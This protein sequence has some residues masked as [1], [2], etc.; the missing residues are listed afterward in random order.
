MVY[1]PHPGIELG[2]V[3]ITSTNDTHHTRFKPRPAV[4]VKIDDFDY[5]LAILTTNSHFA[6]GLPR[7]KV[8]SLRLTG[9]PKDSY[10]WGGRLKVAEPGRVDPTPIGF[11]YWELARAITNTMDGIDE[12]TKTA[13]LK[14]VALHETQ[15]EEA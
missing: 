14:A 10:L 8:D 9:D 1:R 11:C 5:H 3:V 2:H 13:F 4:V 12:E 7:I 15:E 6:N